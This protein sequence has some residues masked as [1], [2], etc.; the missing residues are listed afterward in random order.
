MAG[1]GKLSLEDWGWDVGQVRDTL[2]IPPRR[3]DS[4]LI[5]NQQRL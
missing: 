1:S 5:G 2:S 3:L 4:P